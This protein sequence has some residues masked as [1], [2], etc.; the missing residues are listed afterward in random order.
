MYWGGIVSIGRSKYLSI[1][2]VSTGRCALYRIVDFS[3]GTLS[4]NPISNRLFEL[5]VYFFIFLLLFVFNDS[6]FRPICD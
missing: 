4:F 6:D 2:I 5:M 3:Y 1:P